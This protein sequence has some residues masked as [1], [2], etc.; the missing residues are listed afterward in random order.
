MKRFLERLLG[1]KAAA[2]A[3]LARSPYLGRPLSFDELTVVEGPPVEDA[4]LPRVS[5]VILNYN[6]RHHLELCFGSLEKLDYPRDRLE[7]VLV[8]NGSED[9]SV[10]E[11]RAKHAWV[12]LIE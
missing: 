3:P 8:D 7:V 11:M 2:P 4:R 9:G 12:R 5:I 6:G 10:E 1:A